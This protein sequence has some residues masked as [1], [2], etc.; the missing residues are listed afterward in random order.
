MDGPEFVFELKE[1]VARVDVDNVVDAELALR[2]RRVPLEHR[3]RVAPI[4]RQESPV[5]CLVKGPRKVVFVRLVLRTTQVQGNMVTVG[6]RNV[7][8]RLPKD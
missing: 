5:L 2:L 3:H 8:A 4:G 7:I 6:G 1:E